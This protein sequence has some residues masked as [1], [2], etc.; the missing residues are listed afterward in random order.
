[1]EPVHEDFD[2]LPG[3]LPAGGDIGSENMMTA[4]E[5]TERCNAMPA[6]AGFTVMSK[7]PY[8]PGAVYFKETTN[9]WRPEAQSHTYKKKVAETCA[10]K[11]ETADLLEAAAEL[12]SFSVDILREEPLVAIVRN[13]ARTEEC[14]QLVE[15][16]GDWEQMNG[17]FT[18]GSGFVQE[19]MSY[20]SSIYPPLNDPE[21]HLTRFTALMFTVVRNLTG[22]KVYPPGQ[23]P[24]NAVLYKNRGDEYRPHCDGNCGGGRHNVGER[25]ATSI[26][27]CRAAS[28]G[29]ATHFTTDVLKV[30]PNLGDLL[31]FAYRYPDGRMTGQEAEHSGCPVRKGK[32][33]IATQWYREGVHE[34]WNWEASP[35]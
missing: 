34:L 15:A 14:D 22:Y 30:Q 12:R 16:G 35:W 9:G 25:I 1:V 20:S 27:Y 8:G 5:A 19:R 31:I 28:K 3:V 10:A 17:D 18:S 26:V 33:W 29:G 7:S 6:C 2:Y 4:A 13:F 23:E 24:L 11:S 32:K 21:H